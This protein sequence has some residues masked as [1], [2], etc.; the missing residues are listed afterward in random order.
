VFYVGGFLLGDIYC[1]GNSV[2]FGAHMT[3]GDCLVF[4]GVAGLFVIGSVIASVAISEQVIKASPDFTAMPHYVKFHIYPEEPGLK[5]ALWASDKLPPTTGVT[6]NNSEFDVALLS[7]VKY[8]LWI[9]ER[10][11]SRYIV[12]TMDMYY[13]ECGVTK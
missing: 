4:C 12:P 1:I 6:D 7:T 9:P 13:V 10:K 5:V 3:L 8:N 11:C 2:I